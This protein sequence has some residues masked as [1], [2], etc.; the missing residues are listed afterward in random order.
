MLGFQAGV[1]AADRVGLVWKNPKRW[2]HH[3]DREPAS[4]KGATTARDESG[5]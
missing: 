3:P 2:R 5:G 1:P 4:W